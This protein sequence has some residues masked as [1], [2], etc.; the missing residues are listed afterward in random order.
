[1]ETGPSPLGSVGSSASEASALLY[2]IASFTACAHS[3][4]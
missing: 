2:A 3:S 1:M 4:H